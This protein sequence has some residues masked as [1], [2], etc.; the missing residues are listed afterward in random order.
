MREK[1]KQYLL[2]YLRE[3]L[4]SRTRMHLLMLAGA[5]LANGCVCSRAMADVFTA[6]SII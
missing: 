4:I 1:L 2:K 3:S 6:F 5:L